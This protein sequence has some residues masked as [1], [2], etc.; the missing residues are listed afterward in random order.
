MSTS[1]VP[2]TSVPFTSYA[3]AAGPL[4]R[5][6]CS[7]GSS[8]A[9][10]ARPQRPV[11]STPAPS[12]IEH[13]QRFSHSPHASISNGGNVTPGRLFSPK[14]DSTTTRSRSS[15]RA[16]NHFG[17]G[18]YHTAPK[19]PGMNARARRKLRRAMERAAQ[20]LSASS[21]GDDDDEDDEEA[22]TEA[23]PTHSTPQKHQQPNFESFGFDR[24]PVAY[25]ADE[26]LSP[27][28]LNPTALPFMPITPP[29]RLSTATNAT[30]TSISTAASL[31]IH[32][33]P[34]TPRKSGSSPASIF[35]TP[36]TCSTHSRNYSNASTTVSMSTMA[37]TAV[38]ECDE[39]YEKLQ[40]IAEECEP[41]EQRPLSLG[42][43][44]QECA[45]KAWLKARMQR[46]QEQT[47]TINAQQH[48]GQVHYVARPNTYL[49]YQPQFAAPALP[50]YPTFYASPQFQYSPEG[51][52][53]L[54]DETPRAATFP[55]VIAP[56]P[57]A[58][59]DKKS[60]TFLSSRTKIAIC[61]EVIPGTS[62]PWALT[63]DEWDHQPNV[64][65]NNG[66]HFCYDDDTDRETLALLGL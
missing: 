37:T 43:M 1:R 53:S 44:K 16:R 13:R 24:S 60:S 20:G 66:K 23:A 46:E 2:S 28:S 10:S 27:R 29:R 55:A 49:P 63:R 39:E 62:D 17:H 52:A 64:T 50:M 15:F 32:A 11:I 35:S 26:E 38:E 9:T 21:N 54:N 12:N 25:N 40:H 7:S 3:Q 14:G 65:F 45:L 36:S 56:K 34:F 30:S 59:A 48:G 18:R 33:N 8:I 47:A 57:V 4:T 58:I 42:S 19:E 6:S 22:Q 51:I 41:S 61:A 31:S 5:N